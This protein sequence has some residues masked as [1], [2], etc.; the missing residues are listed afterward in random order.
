MSSDDEYDP[1][2][3]D[4]EEEDDPVEP[5]QESAV[6]AAPS[7]SKDDV[8]EPRKDALPV[9]KDVTTKTV[10]STAEVNDAAEG[11]SGRPQRTR[12]PP[13]RFMFSLSILFLLFG[14]GFAQSREI[15]LREGVV[16]K[17][18][19]ELAFTD[20]EWV[21]VTDFSFEPLDTAFNA[22]DTWLKIKF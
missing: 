19:G 9:G 17:G 16:F 4:T 2:Y 18:E 3:S 11:N 22:V 6:E 5:E 21:V 13:N 20:S 7:G 15:I 1:S 10:P 14:F 8:V 12:R